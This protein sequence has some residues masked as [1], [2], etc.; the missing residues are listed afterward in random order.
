[1]LL[2]QLDLVTHGGGGLVN[3]PWRELDDALSL[4]EDGAQ[5]LRRDIPHQPHNLV[6]A[7]N[8][9]RV[10]GEFHEEHVNGIAMGD[11]QAAPLGQRT[12]A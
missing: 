8:K 6:I 11:V 4:P 2:D 10:D 3:C 12:A 7:V 5:T 1:V 9:D